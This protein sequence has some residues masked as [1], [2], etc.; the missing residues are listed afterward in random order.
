VAEGIV[1]Q[2]E[3]AVD[4]VRIDSQKDDITHSEEGSEIA[5]PDLAGDLDDRG[6]ELGRGRLRMIIHPV[7]D[8]HIHQPDSGD[9]TGAPV[10]VKCVQ[11]RGLRIRGRQT[12]QLK[13]PA[14]E[15]K[16]ESLRESRVGYAGQKSMIDPVQG[17]D[18][19]NTVTEFVNSNIVALVAH[20]ALR[21]AG[22]EMGVV[23]PPHRAHGMAGAARGIDC[24]L[25]RQIGGGCGG[26]TETSENFRQPFLKGRSGRVSG[27]DDPVKFALDKGG[28]RLETAVPDVKGLQ[29]TL[30]TARDEPGH[31]G[32][33]RIGE[34][35]DQQGLELRLGDLPLTVET[36]GDFGRLAGIIGID[37]A[38]GC[39][40]RQEM[41]VTRITFRDRTGHHAI[42]LNQ[43]GMRRPERNGGIDHLLRDL[44]ADDALHH[45]ADHA[46]A[47]Q[48]LLLR[49]LPLEFIP[50][51][52][53]AD[54]LEPL[55][56]K[57]AAP[58][59]D[60]RVH[61]DII[62]GNIIVRLDVGDARCL[63]HRRRHSGVELIGQP[64]LRPFLTAP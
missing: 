6:L 9:F 54:Q 58:L 7:P 63:Q 61:I 57:P 53:M 31:P 3:S 37:P 50:E 29:G 24:Y 42:L 8:A 16:G 33:D 21:N 52:P 1:G 18:L 35:P 28:F 12:E 45:P 15:D 51:S 59:I 40:N 5:V 19:L 62:V 41:G 27:A 44:L 10:G 25:G 36:A 32:S 17:E 49:I 56:K 46:L 47:R 2:I 23:L 43:V 48:P 22:A 55:R 13:I 4:H 39:K 38:F 14:L 34:Q 64:H 20:P 30:Q 26:E 60:Q 11:M